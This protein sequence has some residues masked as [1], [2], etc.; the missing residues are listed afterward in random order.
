M[1]YRADNMKLGIALL[2]EQAISVNKL[3]N[4]IVE[5]VSQ[6]E[7]SINSLNLGV[8][9][10]IQTDRDDIDLWLGYERVGATWGF[11]I[12]SSTI[13]PSP[14]TVVPWQSAPRALRLASIEMIP[15]LIDELIVEANRFT[16]ELH[17]KVLALKDVMARIGV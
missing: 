13:S 8:P 4:E 3:S 6:I 12:M 16:M 11:S 7:T 9:W 10:R 15:R 2:A 5:Y 17:S 1:S 14:N